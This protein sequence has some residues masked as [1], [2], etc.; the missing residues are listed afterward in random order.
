MKKPKK[1]DYGYVPPDNPFLEPGWFIDGG[2]EA[3]DKALEAWEEPLTE[4]D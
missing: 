4:N 1:E 2:E 3:Y